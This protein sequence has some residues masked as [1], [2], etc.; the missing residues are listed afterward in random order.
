[1]T[2]KDQLN[3]DVKDAM[4]ARDK[5]KLDVLRLITAAI[6]QVE[7]DE[8]I[9]IDDARMLVIFDK[10]SK[11]RAESISQFKTAGRDDL[12][13]QEEFELDIIRH[14]MPTPLSQPEIDQM[15]AEAFANIEIKSMADMGKI[16]A[17]LKPQMQGRADMAV[18]SASV[19]NQ[20]NLSL[21]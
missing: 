20:L 21:Q 4:R 5:K 3:S 1:M 12:V 15:I 9:E 6:K 2:I 18:V 17:H 13:Q 14:Y 19:K 8:R 7:V 11:Q 16:M 10:M